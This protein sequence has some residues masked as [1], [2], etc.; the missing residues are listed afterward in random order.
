MKRILLGVALSAFMSALVVPSAWGS[1]TFCAPAIAQREA[2]ALVD[3]IAA[4]PNVEAA[5]ALALEP[6]RGAHF[7]LTQARRLS[8]WTGSLAAADEKLAGY[9]TRIAAASSPDAVAAEMATLA[10]VH[11]DF[12]DGGCSYSPGEVVAVVLGFI[13]WIIP[14]II[15][16][17]LLC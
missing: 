14:G 13:L 17:F 9:E 16:L 4:A 11:A 5:R 7:A 8:P 6:T 10:R 1:E 2:A 15:L 3:R 12:G